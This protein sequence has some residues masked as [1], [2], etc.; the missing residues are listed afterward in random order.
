MQKVEFSRISFRIT[1]FFCFVFFVNTGYLKPLVI[2]QLNSNTLK[3][4]E[5]W[6]KNPLKISMGFIRIYISIQGYSLKSTETLKRHVFIKLGCRFFFLNYQ[7][8]KWNRLV[9]NFKK[10][11]NTYRYTL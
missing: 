4:L 9:T 2:N 8:M 1:I 11:F 3:F 10:L 5:F 7:S 6:Y